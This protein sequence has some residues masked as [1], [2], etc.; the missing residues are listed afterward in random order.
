GVAT[1]K[2]IGGNMKTL[3]ALL[4]SKSDLQTDHHILF[5]EDTGEYAYSIDRLFW[6]FQ[7]AGK[8]DHIKGL[9]VGGFK[10]K[11][12]EDPDGFALTVPELVWEKLTDCPFPV[13]FDFPVGH[14]K[15]NLPLKC[16]VLHR[17]EVADSGVV[18]TSLQ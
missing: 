1:A 12:D 7:R 13:C 3:E 14:Q 10:V 9:I 16:G 15:H 4:N 11:K 2:L 18:L 8:L 17:L 6:T 5:L